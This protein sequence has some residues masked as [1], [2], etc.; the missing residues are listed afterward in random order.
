MWSNHPKGT[1]K[2]RRHDSI[3]Q[4][5]AE[6]IIAEELD[7]AIPDMDSK[8]VELAVKASLKQIPGVISVRFVERGA[9]ARYNP[10]AINKNQI[11]TA[12]QQAGYH[13]SIFQGSMTGPTGRSSQ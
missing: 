6:H 5:N 13:A 12:V 11:C 2:A 7:L 1:R 4:M 8:T 9:F 10:N 3:A